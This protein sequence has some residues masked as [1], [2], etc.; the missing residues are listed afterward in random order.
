MMVLEKFTLTHLL[1]LGRP[2]TPLIFIHS[3]YY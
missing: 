3:H 2:S 1:L